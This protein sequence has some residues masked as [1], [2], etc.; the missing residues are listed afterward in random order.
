MLFLSPSYKEK[1]K[2]LKSINK[3]LPKIE[4]RCYLK[5]PTRKIS[6]KNLLK[7]FVQVSLDIFKS[8]K[9]YLLNYLEDIDL[10]KKVVIIDQKSIFA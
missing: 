10:I 3:L 8:K 2:E 4:K 1:I 5:W 6:Y 9:V 7:V